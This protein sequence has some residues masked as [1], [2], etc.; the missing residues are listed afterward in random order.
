MKRASALL[1]LAAAGTAQ[2]SFLDTDFWCVNYGCAV[3]H[4]GTTYDIYDNWQFDTNS[5]CVPAGGQMVS[6]YSRAGVP[7][8]T[9]TLDPVGPG[10]DE[11]QSLM[12]EIA[13]G[14]R[15]LSISDDGDGYLDA[16][17]TL[18]AFTLGA[19]TDVQLPGSVG[20]YSHSFFVS[21]RDT[22]FSLRALAQID[23]AT[24]DF[25]DTVTLGDIKLT[26]SV[27]RRGDDDGWVFGQQANPGGIVIVNTVDDLGDLASG[28]TQI[29]DFRRRNGIRRRNADINEQVIRLDF[30]YEL[31][32]Y[33][34]SMGSG[35]FS[36]DVEFLF[37]RER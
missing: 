19:D 3:V 10:P 22:R 20:T 33:D 14:S 6:F 31:P 17:D 4:D 29:M 11:S 36:V 37:Y 18:G 23:Q 13:D 35:E 5:C 25:A 1:C 24:G 12:L 9:G 26:P 28:P 15:I 16:S 8:I 30:L 7:R 32:A 27:T 2:A 21:S 34:M